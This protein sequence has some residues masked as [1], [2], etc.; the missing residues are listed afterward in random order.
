MSDDKNT[1]K[2]I[3]DAKPLYT[4]TLI[5]PACSAA[6]GGT[7]LEVRFESSNGSAQLECPNCEQVSAL[8]VA[9]TRHARV[10][11]A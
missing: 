4:T 11:D 7:R 8:P 3:T 10:K 9:V 2:D 6:T 1:I 5:C